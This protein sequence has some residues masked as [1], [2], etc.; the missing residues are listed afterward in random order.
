MKKDGST[1]EI[2]FKLLAE[3]V[4]TVEIDKV[5]THDSKTNQCLIG[6]KMIT[7]IQLENLKQ[8]V[9]LLK[10]SSLLGM[11][12]ETLKY[13]ARMV[14]FEKARTIEDLQ[15]GKS[16]LHSIGIIETILKK[17]EFTKISTGSN[18]AV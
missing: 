5:F 7:P 2:L 6:G 12:T 9:L 14:M 13:E 15:W 10:K 18:K 16:I 4:R 3:K 11:F 8:E 17:I 1:E